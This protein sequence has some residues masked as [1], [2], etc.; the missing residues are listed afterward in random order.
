MDSLLLLGQDVD[1]LGEFLLREV[2]GC[3]GALSVG[4]DPASP[5]LI[6][7][8]DKTRPNEDALLIRKEG[9]RWL[10]AVAD[11]H[12]GQQTSHSL[13]RCLYDLPK[14]PRRL[15]Q[16]SLAL[17]ALEMAPDN[18]SGSTLLV[19]VLN[20]LTG[21]CWG[22]SY[23]DSS[24]MT[25][26]S[27]VVTLRNIHNQS[28]LRGPGAL[29]VDLGQPFEFRLA[30]GE[31]LLLFTDGVNECCYRSPERSVGEAHL[32][33]LVNSST[34]TESLARGLM[35]MS[36]AGVDGNA[37]GQDNVAIVAWSLE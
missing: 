19:A 27:Q 36:L 14:L 33:R 29:A 9:E 20:E 32:Q 1:R 12:H 23:G 11:G 25:A 8:G 24:V 26:S 15:G 21:D 2:A 10:L 17:A 22:I 4:S 5:S 31:K 13:L 34:G 3:W 37:G 28:Y 6:H 30:P 35:E 7:K 18:G 16:L